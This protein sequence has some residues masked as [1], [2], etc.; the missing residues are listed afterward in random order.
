MIKKKNNKKIA[1]V[2]GIGAGA[3]A[4][5]A[6]SYFLFGPEGKKHRKQTKE[7]MDNMKNEVMERV[8]DM[9]DIS[10]DT[11]HNII[12]TIVF[13]YMATGEATHPELQEFAESLKKQ[14]KNI[15]KLPAK[16]K[17]KSSKKKA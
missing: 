8:G 2:V 13:A 6:G 11:F 16:N 3:A 17:K 9:K 1:K 7:W 4:I 10:E 5:A 14:W 15:A 12:D